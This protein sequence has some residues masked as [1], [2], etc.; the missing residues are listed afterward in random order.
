MGE[1]FNV[2]VEV[3]EVASD[4]EKAMLM[5]QLQN[6]DSEKMSCNETSA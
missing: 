6:S 5:A 1:T 2:V 4:S 3:N